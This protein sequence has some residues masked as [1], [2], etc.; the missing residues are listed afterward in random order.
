MPDEAR[1]PTRTVFPERFWIHAGIRAFWSA[2]SAYS[3][4]ELF[5]SAETE[6]GR[7][8]YLNFSEPSG[9]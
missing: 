9:S 8:E 5:P 7:C 1:M 2:G 6:P 4:K 3:A